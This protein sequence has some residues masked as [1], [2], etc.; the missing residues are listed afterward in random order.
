MSVP[1]AASG[2]RT[3]RRELPRILT[4]DRF[5]LLEGFILGLTTEKSGAVRHPPQ[6]P[7]PLDSITRGHSHGTASATA[8]TVQYRECGIPRQGSNT[9][10]MRD[11]MPLN[12]RRTRAVDRCNTSTC[13][14]PEE[15]PKAGVRVPG[16]FWLL[17]CLGSIVVMAAAGG[18]SADNRSSSYLPFGPSLTKDMANKAVVWEQCDRI[19]SQI[20]R[21][22]KEKGTSERDGDPIRIGPYGSASGPQNKCRPQPGHAN[23]RA[24]GTE[25]FFSDFL[26]QRAWPGVKTR[27]VMRA[28]LSSFESLICE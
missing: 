16:S 28:Q 3:G 20:D 7:L 22:G 21:S 5:N 23:K 14:V 13:C 19:C 25:S 4:D 26:E 2:W 15:Q 6:A 12:Q 17:L 10:A 24:P 11:P 18:L 1:L 27:F 9:G 8:V